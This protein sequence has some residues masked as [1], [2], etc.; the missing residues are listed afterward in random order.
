M[1]NLKKND[2]LPSKIGSYNTG[3][4]SFTNLNIWLRTLCVKNA[5]GAF[6]FL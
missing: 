5:S 3:S 4:K 2:P 1:S 6:F